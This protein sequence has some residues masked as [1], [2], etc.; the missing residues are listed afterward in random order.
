MD[1]RVIAERLIGYD[2]SEADGLRSAFGFVKGWLEA[3]DIDV[4]DFELNGMPILAC[5]VGAGEQRIIYHG[6][7]DI[8]P[9]HEDQF[10][11]RNDGDRLYGRGAYDMKGA[12]ASMMCATYDL[13][14]QSNARVSLVLVPDE[15]SEDTSNKASDYMVDQGFVGDFAITGEPTD[16]HIGIAAKGVL[17]VRI[18]I[19]GRAAHGSTPWLG[20]NAVLKAMNTLRK[21]ES[22]S[23]TE[24]SSE[25]FE[26]PSINLG[27]IIGGDAVNKV[28]DTCVMDLDIR[29]VPG[30]EPT[31]IMREIEGLEDIEIVKHFIRPPAHVNRE[32]PYVIALGEAIEPHAP[33]E[34]LSVGRDGT[35]D[36]VCFLKAGVPAVE[37]GPQ[38]EGHHG[39]DE[40][41]SIESLRIY[42]SALVDFIEKLPAKQS[43][44]QGSTG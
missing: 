40:W 35:S 18:M 16:F 24:R 11:A 28:P 38:G 29:F 44:N 13:R 43:E 41:V 3:R 6:H 5:E 30:E 27:R 15:E 36:A 33:Y 9:G 32:N 12:V 10:E 25:L 37:F 20:D 2:T 23:F 14:D 7:L 8:V 34:V 31:E 17:A 4:Q 22:L 42:K 39:P 21:I 19:S 1:E 26:R